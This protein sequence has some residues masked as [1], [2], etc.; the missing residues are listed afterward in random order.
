MR[1]LALYPNSYGYHR[2]PTGLVILM[3]LLRRAGHTLDLFDTTFFAS[4]NTD[5]DLREKAGVVKPVAMPFAYEGLSDDAV[6]ALFRDKLAAF[7]PDLVI[8][9]LIE[10]NY[11]YGDRFLRMVKAFDPALPVLVGGPTPT[12]APMVVIEHPCIDYLIQGEGEE[13]IVEFCELLEQGRDVQGVAN[14][15]TMRDGR[16]HGNPLR[17]F[18]DMNDLPVYD[19]TL[20][21]ERHMLKPYDGRVWRTGYFESSRG[22]PFQCTYCVNPTIQ[23]ELSSAGRFFRRKSPERTVAE[24][25]LHK[26]RHG[27][28]R[29]VFCDDNFLLMSPAQF[30]DYARVFVPLWTREVGLPYW[31]STSAEFIRRE[32][33]EML[34]ATGCDGIGLG[35]EAGGEWF[36]RHVLRRNLSNER[37][38]DTFR[39]IH[40]YGIRTTANVMIGF[41]GEIESDIMDTIR[42]LRRIAPRSFDVSF[43]SPYVGTGIQRV[44]A[45]LGLI[46]LS[47]APGFRGMAAEIAFRGRPT[48]RNPD[49]PERRLIEIQDGFADFVLD[50]RPLPETP[51]GARGEHS[52]A[53]ARLMETERLAPPQNPAARRRQ[54]QSGEG[55]TKVTG[56]S[57]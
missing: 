30:A 29:V 52:L 25:R 26:E 31:I 27:L 7:R 22:C 44:A 21:D 47:D 11:R 9:T 12:A 34:T 19:M 3:T 24:A 14:L 40:E 35:V 53:V 49:I 43:A 37:L 36:R 16:P 46:E 38:V 28:E 33:L 23:N 54:G 57:A 15:W 50:R 45:K 17:P 2:V 41:P 10:D 55:S 56:V 51:V 4:S 1:I 18:I 39:L 48:I 42:L 8:V 32:T 20:W 13:A 6:G 5:N